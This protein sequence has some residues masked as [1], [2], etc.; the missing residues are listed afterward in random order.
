MATDELK[1][2]IIEMLIELAQEM[3]VDEFSKLCESIKKIA[4]ENE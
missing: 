3:S 2:K 4:H 1:A